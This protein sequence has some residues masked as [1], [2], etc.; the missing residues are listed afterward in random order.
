MVV[1][2]G[3]V[4]VDVDAGDSLFREDGFYKCGDVVLGDCRVL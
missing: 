2:E 3:E 1:A 4:A